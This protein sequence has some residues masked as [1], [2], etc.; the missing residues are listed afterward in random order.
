MQDRH[1]AEVSSAIGTL[2]SAIK[3]AGFTIFFGLMYVG[4]MI[5]SHH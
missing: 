5:A 3:A 4:C 2:A 1:V